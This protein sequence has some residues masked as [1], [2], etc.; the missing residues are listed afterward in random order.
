MQFGIIRGKIDR[1]IETISS[2]NPETT[3]NV[4]NEI[5]KY[6]ILLLGGLRKIFRRSVQ[7][8]FIYKQNYNEVKIKCDLG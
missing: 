2:V 1:L 8:I 4:R 7:V 3:Q 5:E 6:T